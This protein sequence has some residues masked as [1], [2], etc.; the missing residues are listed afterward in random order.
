[1]HGMKN[2][3]AMISVKRLN[4]LSSHCVNIEKRTFL[5]QKPP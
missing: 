2:L 5:K 3:Y 1:M 4:Q